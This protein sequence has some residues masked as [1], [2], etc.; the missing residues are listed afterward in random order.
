MQLRHQH[1]SGFYHHQTYTIWCKFSS[2]LLIVP[3][4]TRAQ[5]PQYEPPLGCHATISVCRLHCQTIP[6]GMYPFPPCST[7][8]NLAV[9]MYEIAAARLNGFHKYSLIKINPT[10]Q[11]P[12]KKYSSTNAI[13]LYSMP[14]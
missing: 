14:R 7:D 2:T 12:P 4:C 10:L 1:E 3:K 6:T 5:S 11:V 9:Y 13:L 8:V